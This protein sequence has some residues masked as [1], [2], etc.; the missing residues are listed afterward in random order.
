MF[1][2]EYNDAVLN[3]FRTLKE[4][5]NV[6]DISISNEVITDFFCLYDPDIEVMIT[7][8]EHY[9]GRLRYVNCFY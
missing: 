8:Y 3:I 2:K 5:K 9:Q 1:D 7:I 6:H 4:A